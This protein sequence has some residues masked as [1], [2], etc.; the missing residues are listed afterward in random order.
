[1][2]EGTGRRREVAVACSKEEMA[3]RESAYEVEACR[4]VDHQR[5]ARIELVDAWRVR[6]RAEFVMVRTFQVQVREESCRCLVDGY[7]VGRSD[8]Q[9][10][11][12]PDAFEGLA[13]DGWQ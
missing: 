9:A 7:E 1:M 2:E 8:E 13:V 4:E 6:A 5:V 3:G 11:S 12:C 10:S